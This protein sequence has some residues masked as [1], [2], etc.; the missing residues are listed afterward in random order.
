MKK[1]IILSFIFYSLS[2]MQTGFLTPKG[3]NAFGFFLTENK[4]VEHANYNL[5]ENVSLSYITTFGLEFGASYFLEKNHWDKKGLNIS[6][7]FNLLLCKLKLI[8]LKIFN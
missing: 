7:H 1:N 4:N 3:V 6:Y 8:Y 2:F 5:I